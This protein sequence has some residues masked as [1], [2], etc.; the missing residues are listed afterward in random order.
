MKKLTI[1][2]MAL[3]AMSCSSDYMED[4]AEESKSVEFVI[5]DEYRTM[6][7]FVRELADSELFGITMPDNP[8]YDDLMQL[9][10]A[11]VLSDVF[12]DTFGEGDC[13]SEYR[14]MHAYFSE[15]Y[16]NEEITRYLSYILDNGIF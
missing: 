12:G 6:Y 10:A 11:A 5:S 1:I 13:E 8:T 14:L 2:V 7:D 15:R 3:L 16:P 4:Y 9:S